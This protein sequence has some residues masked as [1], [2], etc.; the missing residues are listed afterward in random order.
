MVKTYYKIRSRSLDLY[1]K[2]T[3]GYSHWDKEGRL[4]T[5]IGQLRSFMT[6]TM[7]QSDSRNPIDPNDWEIREYSMT[8]LD[9]KK[10]MDVIKPEKIIQLLKRTA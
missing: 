3:P 1:L 7:N 9:C 5:S 4:F 2:G 8:L 6:S 10:V